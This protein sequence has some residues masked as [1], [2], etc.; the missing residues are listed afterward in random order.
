MLHDLTSRLPLHCVDKALTV[1]DDHPSFNF[2]QLRQGRVVLSTFRCRNLPGGAPGVYRG[3]FGCH[4][5]RSKLPMFENRV[6]QFPSLHAKHP[7][8]QLTGAPHRYQ[9]LH[10]F[11]RSPCVTI[12]PTPF[13]FF[14]P[15]SQN[16][17]ST[18]IANRPSSDESQIGKVSS[19]QGPRVP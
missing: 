9:S 13:L 1:S 10:S 11:C 15:K 4:A 12:H 18:R 17:A 19:M 2:L 6:F 8:K 14:P 16:N 5:Q 7:K 3:L